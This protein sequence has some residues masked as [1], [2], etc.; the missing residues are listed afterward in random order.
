MA[1]PL[2]TR[3]GRQAEALREVKLLRHLQH[4][5]VMAIRD[6]MPPSSLSEFDDLY[7]VSEL[8]DTDLHQIIRSAQTLTDEHFQFFVYQVRRSLLQALFSQ[9]SSARHCPNWNV[10][11]QQ[12]V[13]DTVSRLAAALRP[14]IHPQR[15]RHTQR[16]EALQPPCQRRLHAENMR[17][18]AGQDRVSSSPQALL[19]ACTVQSHHQSRPS[20]Q[21]S[22]LA[23]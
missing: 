6:I 17:F 12:R 15:E 3:P 16:P 9:G 19:P 10:V 23:R 7:V 21:Q 20:Q 14:Q 11:P 18:R 13:T 1:A 4:A 8:M 2:P 5:N 22:C